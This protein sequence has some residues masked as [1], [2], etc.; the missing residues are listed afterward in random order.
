MNTIT[1]SK[2]FHVIFFLLFEL[3]NERVWCY[4]YSKYRS[5]HRR[6]RRITTCWIISTPRCEKEEGNPRAVWEVR[7]HCLM[8]VFSY[9]MYELFCWKICGK[10]FKVLLSTD[11]RGVDLK[12]FMRGRGISS[13]GEESEPQL[14]P[15]SAGLEMSGATSM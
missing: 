8:L 6:W 9:V 14:L 5:G 12:I 2:K 10:N 1:Q 13:E 4:D 11:W 15:G 3:F 7:S